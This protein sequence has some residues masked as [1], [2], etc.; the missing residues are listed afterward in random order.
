MPTRIGP[1]RPRKLY[2]VEWREKISPTM[3]QAMLASRVGVS[4]MTVSRWERNQHKL[5]TDTIA[6]VAE[7]FAE[8][9]GFNVEPT[10]LYRHPDTPSADALLRGASP[11]VVK[12]AI[13]MIS[14]IRTRR[15]S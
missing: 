3:T 5:N 9:L 8:A 12:E 1:K 15:A 2:L 13:D 7:A 14:Y 10:D 6:A 4:E 11:E